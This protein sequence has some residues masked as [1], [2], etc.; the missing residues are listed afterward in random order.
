M[1][2]G[3]KTKT[4]LIIGVL[5]GALLA[6]VEVAPS[7]EIATWLKF[8]GTIFMNIGSGMTA[9]GVAHKVEKSNAKDSGFMDIRL[10]GLLAAAMA[11]LIISSAGCGHRQVVLTPDQEIDRAYYEALNTFSKAEKEFTGWLIT[12]NNW[13][14]NPEYADACKVADPYWDKANTALD[15][16]GAVVEAKK[17]SAFEQDVYLNELKALKTKML[18]EIPNFKW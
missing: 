11:I 14:E 12:Y 4:G 2:K 18:M 15:A 1:L 10:C 5:G 8:L 17:G 3:W 9:Y 6:G 16:W 7:P 13:C